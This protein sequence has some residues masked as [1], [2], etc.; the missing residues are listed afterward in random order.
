MRLLSVALTAQGL[1][2]RHLVVPA[3]A[4]G[5]DVV[6][7][8]PRQDLMAA[9]ALPL[10]A[11]QQ[12]VIGLAAPLDPPGDH[13]AKDHLL[14]QPW[15]ALTI[16][17]H[18][19]PSPLH[20]TIARPLEEIRNLR[21]DLDLHNGLPVFLAR[22]EREVEAHRCLWRIPQALPVWPLRLVEFLLDVLHLLRGTVED[23]RRRLRRAHV[24]SE[25][26]GSVLHHLLVWHLVVLVGR[27]PQPPGLRLVIHGQLQGAL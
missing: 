16:V 15:H 9:I 8:R 12:Y 7:L 2:V 20:E 17:D 5:L 27:H 25:C 14:D 21:H 4:Q 23:L 6:N 11:L 10:L 18:M 3:E 1:E 24:R 13:H 26:R 22:L 19:V